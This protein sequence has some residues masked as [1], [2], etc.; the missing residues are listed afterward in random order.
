MAKKVKPSQ[1]SVALEDII[2]DYMRTSSEV[3]Q[4]ALQVGAEVFRDA[5]AAVTPIDTGEMADSWQIKTKCKDRKYVGNTRVAKGVVHRK[6]KDGSMG[7]AREGVPLS[8][9]LE[10]SDKSPH[11]GFIRRCFDGTEPQIFAAIKYKLSN[12]G[13]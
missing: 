1:M 9:V 11:K 6:T 4:E 13:K 7:E 8:N 3:R 10:Y 12:G 2:L 5:V